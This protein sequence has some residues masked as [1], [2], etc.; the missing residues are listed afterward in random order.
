MPSRRW[1][2][3]VGLSGLAGFIL[4]TVP[5]GGTEEIVG[6]VLLTFMLVAV[7]GLVVARLGPQSQP[8]REREALAREEFDRT[9]RWPD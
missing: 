9:G 2:V 5:D 8:E 3:A 7:I 1:M 6:T 4:L